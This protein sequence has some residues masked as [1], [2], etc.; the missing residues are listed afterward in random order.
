MQSVGTLFAAGSLALLG[1]CAAKPVEIGTAGGELTVMTA[2]P[3]P[4]GFDTGKLFRLGADDLISVR[5]FGS[6]E[7]SVERTRLDKSGRLS[8]PIGGMIEAGGMTVA[9]LEDA[10]E[11]A[12]RKNYFR[13]PQVS[14]SLVE[15]A[16]SVYTVGGGVTRPGLFPARPK[17]TLMQAIAVAEGTSEDAKQNEV[18]VFRTIDGKKY[19]ALYDLR[20]I[21]RGNYADPRIFPDDIVMVGEVASRSLFLDAVTAIGTLASPIILLLRN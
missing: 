6:P 14:V 2:L 8:V 15:I 18:V 16:S 1:G 20:A 7:A 5:V 12:L 3:E 10:I 9:E 21:R 11:A 4:A 17:L 13:D 19:A